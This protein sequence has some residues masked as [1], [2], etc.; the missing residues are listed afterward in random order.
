MISATPDYLI[1]P[2]VA[3]MDFDLIVCSEMDSETP[4]KYRF[5]C[6]GINKVHALNALIAAHDIAP[7]QILRAYSDDKS[8][9]PMMSLAKEPVWINPQTGARKNAA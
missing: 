9:R 2:L 5:F 6:Y 8:D 1:M 3:D 7:R 4:W